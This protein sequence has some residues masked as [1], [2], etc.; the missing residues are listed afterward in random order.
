MPH[1]VL[2]APISMDDIRHQFKPQ[3]ST[4]ND[5]HVKLAALFQSQ[6][7]AS[8]LVETYI[9]E[10]P[11]AQRIGLAIKQRNEGEFVLSLHEIGFPR[12]TDG[13]H[14]AITAL[15][16]WLVALHPDANILRHN[17]RRLNMDS[18]E[19]GLE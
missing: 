17:L 14:F 15:A 16:D 3:H 1:L 6:D 11:I 5:I 2:A 8:L 13:V 10:E 4:K 12:V 7:E 18:K 19:I 9:K